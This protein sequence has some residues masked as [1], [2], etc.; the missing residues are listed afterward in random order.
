MSRVAA[1]VLGENFKDL[2]EHDGAVWIRAWYPGQRVKFAA[3]AMEPSTAESLSEQDVRL[4][5][6]Q[7]WERCLARE[8]ARSAALR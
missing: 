3:L 8:S 5:L 7:N 2:T 1:E 4:L 6:S